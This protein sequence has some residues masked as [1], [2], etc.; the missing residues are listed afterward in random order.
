MRA[1]RPLNFSFAEKPVNCPACGK[2]SVVDVVYAPMD[3]AT[4][5]AVRQGKLIQGNEDPSA[6][7]PCWGCT[8]CGTVFFCEE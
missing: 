3:E 2:N 5:E 1:H 4:A 8:S 7:H 6:P